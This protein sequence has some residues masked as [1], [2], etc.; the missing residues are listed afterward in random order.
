VARR[1]VLNT[2]ALT[3]P[4]PR[5]RHSGQQLGQRRL[6]GEGVPAGD[7]EQ[8]HRLGPRRGEQ[9]RG[10]LGAHADR[11]DQTL[12]PES[13]QAGDPGGQGGVEVVLL[14]SCR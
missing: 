8:V 3:T 6:L 2:A 13:D 4:T 9:R 14:G 12:L 10:G 11:V 5:R 1:P 7:H